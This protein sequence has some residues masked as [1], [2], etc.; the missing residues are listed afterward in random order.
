[1]RALNRTRAPGA[2]LSLSPRVAGGLPPFIRIERVDFSPPILPHS[3]SD[4]RPPLLP[5][6]PGPI[7][8]ND[9]PPLPLF[10]GAKRKQ[11]TP[12]SS[13]PSLLSFPRRNKP[14]YVFLAPPPSLG[15]QWHE[16]VHNELLLRSF[17]LLYFR[18]LFLRSCY[19]K[20][21]FSNDTYIYVYSKY[22]FERRNNWKSE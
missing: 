13:R 9:N 14:I 17:L 1:M 7:E 12:Q 5:P 22:E 21:T 11:I 10:R 6:T 16:R 20:T 3:S 18:R 4:P 8:E 2:G 15:L 19:A